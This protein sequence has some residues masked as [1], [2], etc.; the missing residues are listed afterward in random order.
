MTPIFVYTSN[1]ADQGLVGF[2]LALSHNL[3]RPVRLLPLA[4]LPQPDA[5]RLQ[6]KRV[7]QRDLL[8]ALEAAETHLALYASGDLPPDA[9]AEAGLRFTLESLNTRLKGVQAVLSS[10]EIGGQDNG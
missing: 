4:Q 8:D 6:Q 3:R 9:G 1:P 7:E 10:V 5:L 2:V